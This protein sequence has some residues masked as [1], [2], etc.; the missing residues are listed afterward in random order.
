MAFGV[1]RAVGFNVTGTTSSRRFNALERA[2]RVRAPA[3]DDRV[4]RL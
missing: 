1:G 3:V 2:E 4:I